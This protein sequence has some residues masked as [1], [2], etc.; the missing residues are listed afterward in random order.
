MISPAASEAARRPGQ[1]RV[2]GP[3]A[4]LRS[5]LPPPVDHDIPVSAVARGGGHLP[6]TRGVRG[7]GLIPLTI[8]EIRTLHAN[9]RQPAHPALTTST[10]HAGGAATKQRP[11]TATTSADAYE[12]TNC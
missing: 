9:F 10:G 12:A 4:R 6:A 11:V 8:N 2:P 3:A 5:R 1:G 7:Q